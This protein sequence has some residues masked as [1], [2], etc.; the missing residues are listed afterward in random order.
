MR[1]AASAAALNLHG[2]SLSLHPAGHIL[3]SAQVRVEFEG[4][5]WVVSGDYRVAPN[6]TCAPFEPVRCHTFLTESTFA[7]PHYRWEDDSITFGKLHTWWDSARADGKACL[8][9]A[10]VLGKAQRLVSALDPARGTLF[11]HDWVEDFNVHY[12]A[13]GIALPETRPLSSLAAD[14]WAGAM[15]LLPPSSRWNIGFPLQGHFESAFASGWMVLP[16][17]VA[18]RN[19]STGFALSDHADHEELLKAIAATGA[20]QILVTHGYIDEF[21]SE[22]RTLG[23]DAQPHVTP[24]SKR[25]PR[26]PM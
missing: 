21:V 8:L 5:I 20:S 7:H 12:R 25:P 10:Y 9:Y 13:E 6:E 11:V 26:V 19:V 14:N 1:R 22:L 18:E 24:H 17:E 23:Y 16:G 2:V 3:G 4:E 15:I